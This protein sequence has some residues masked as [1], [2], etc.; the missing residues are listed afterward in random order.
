MNSRHHASGTP[1]SHDFFTFGND[2]IGLHHA[3]ERRANERERN[4]LAG[5]RPRPVS[6]FRRRLGALLISAGQDLRGE[7]APVPQP[8]GL[9][10]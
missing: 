6:A 8:S 10:G 3:E 2:G 5:Y 4:R 9:R 7:C 1:I